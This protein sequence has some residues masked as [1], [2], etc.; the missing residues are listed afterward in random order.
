MLGLSVVLE[1][2][3]S[4]TINKNKET[5]KVINKIM[6]LNSINKQSPI[7][8]LNSCSQHETHFH[9]QQTTFLEICFL[10]KKKL[11]PGTDIYMY[12]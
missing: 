7:V 3:K 11:L 12:K 1:A 6:M 9:E 8:S 10:C 5:P 2:Q 4:G